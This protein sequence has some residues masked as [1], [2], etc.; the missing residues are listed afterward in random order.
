MNVAARVKILMIM[1]REC[2]KRKKGLNVQIKCDPKLLPTPKLKP[3]VAVR[4]PDKPKFVPEFHLIPEKE[5]NEKLEKARR[6]SYAS[7]KDAWRDDE[8]RTLRS[9]VKQGY[10]YKEIAPH[11]PDRTTA[12]VEARIRKMRKRGEL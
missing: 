10:G 9:M 11:L 6:S 4:V 3:T 2:R 5:F 8:I 1:K 12:A 7:R